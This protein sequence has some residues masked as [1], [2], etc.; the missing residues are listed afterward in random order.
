MAAL[1]QRAEHLVLAGARANKTQ[2]T[3][4]SCWRSF[5]QWCK[6]V[7]RQPLPATEE[8]VCL[9]LAHQG[10]RLKVASVR[11]HAWAIEHYHTQAG[12]S[13]PVDKRARGLLSGLAREV[14]LQTDPKLAVMPDQLRAML[15]SLDRKAA[16]GARDAA[17]LLLGFSTGLRRSDLS[18]LDL[19][20]LKVMDEGVLVSVGRLKREKQDQGGRGR[21]IAVHPGGRVATCPVQA[22]TSWLEWRGSAAGPLF[23]RL[24][25]AAGPLE[26]MSGQ[27]LATVVQ[28][29]AKMAGLD[30]SAYGGHSLRAGMVTALSA[31]GVEDSVIM[32]RSGHASVAMLGRYIRPAELFSVNP[33]AGVL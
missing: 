28:R 3:Y 9:Y 14:G 10:A 20:D 12:K 32:A 17:V 30:P 31:S 4:A 15:G 22:L 8:T 33:L 1:R 2:R 6:D 18:A 29:A 16:R 27:S 19:A 11:C 25:Y 26:R 24:D 5:G 21:R 7:G 13:S 23:V